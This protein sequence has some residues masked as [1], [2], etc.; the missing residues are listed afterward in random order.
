MG[1]GR[2]FATLTDRLS[3]FR[4]RLRLFFL[5]IVIVPM[6]SVTL[7]VFRLIAESEHGQADARV[8]ARQDAAISLYYEDR[9]DADR[10]AKRIGADP[11]LAAALRRNRPAEV[12]AAARR[13]LAQTA[14]A[15]VLVSAGGRP[16]AHLGAPHAGL[17]AP[18]RPATAPP[19]TSAP[20]TRSS[21]PRASWSTVTSRSPGCR[22]RRRTRR[23]SPVSS[24][25]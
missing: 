7:I 22:S 19:P 15:R 3:S 1:D 17:P 4:T 24:G 9:A 16:L 10:I 5:L 14:A 6:I 12:Q 8:A 25:A 20:A 23:S 11:G 2:R 13:L 21:R 18:C